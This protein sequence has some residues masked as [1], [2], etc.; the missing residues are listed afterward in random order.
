[1]VNIQTHSLVTP[2][3][4]NAPRNKRLRPQL[5]ADGLPFFRGDTQTARVQGGRSKN[6]TLVHCSSSDTFILVRLVMQAFASGI[7]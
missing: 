1:M 5:L 6:Q 7:P 2:S 3:K 4:Q